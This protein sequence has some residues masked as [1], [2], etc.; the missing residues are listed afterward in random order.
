MLKLSMPK[1]GSKKLSMPS[2][3]NIAERRGAQAAKLAGFKNAGST[4]GTIRPAEKA[5]AHKP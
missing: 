5:R 2:G 1:K 4:G 3:I